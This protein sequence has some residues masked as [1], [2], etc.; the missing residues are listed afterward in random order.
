VNQVTRSAEPEEIFQ[1][2]RAFGCLYVERAF[3]PYKLY[4]PDDRVSCT[5]IVKC[6]M[7]ISML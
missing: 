7:N 3:C 6:G 2:P 4:L 1:F 5:Y